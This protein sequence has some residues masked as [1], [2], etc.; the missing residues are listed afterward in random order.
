MWALLENI[1]LIMMYKVG[2]GLLSY[3]SSKGPEQPIHAVWSGYSLSTYTTVSIASISR[4]QRPWLAYAHDLG[5]RC[6]Q[7]A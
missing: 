2:K 5:L 1:T 6:P 4:Q 3:A 7:I